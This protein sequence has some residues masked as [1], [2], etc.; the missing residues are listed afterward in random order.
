MVWANLTVKWRDKTSVKT[1]S[2]ESVKQLNTTPLSSANR[3]K[4]LCLLTLALM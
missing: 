1:V 3:G 2:R 4:K